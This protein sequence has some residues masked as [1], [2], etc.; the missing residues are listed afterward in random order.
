MLRRVRDWV[1]SRYGLREI[2]LPEKYRVDAKHDVVVDLQLV[3]SLLVYFAADAEQLSLEQSSE[4]LRGRSLY[5]ELV[6]HPGHR[7]HAYPNC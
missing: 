3:A 1:R 7:S 5:E 2:I 4:T 6:S